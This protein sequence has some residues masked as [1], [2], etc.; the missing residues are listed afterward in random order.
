L[1]WAQTGEMLSL[2]DYKNMKSWGANVVRVALK[3]VKLCIIY[4]FIFKINQS[5]Y[6]S[7]F[8]PLQPRFLVWVAWFKWGSLPGSCST[9]GKH[10]ILKRKVIK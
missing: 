8:P 5:N 10:A 4:L 9:T 3:Y 1:E 6:F 2:Q 7:F